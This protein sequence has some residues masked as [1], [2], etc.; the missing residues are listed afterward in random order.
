MSDYK[1]Y[2]PYDALNSPLIY[3]YREFPLFAFFMTVFFRY[4]PINLREIMDT[5]PMLN[6]KALGLIISSYSN[7]VR[8]N[9]PIVSIAEIEKLVIILLRLKSK[10]YSGVSWGYPFPW[11]NRVR[12]TERYEPSIV[13][14]S[15]VAHSLLDYYDLCNNEKI[16]MAVRKACDFITNNLNIKEFEN[17][18]CFGY[19]PGEKNVILNASAL[20]ASLLYRVGNYTDDE[21]L[22]SI[23]DKAMSFLLSRQLPD[24][25]WEYSYDFTS[26]I[27]RTQTDWHQG[28][29]LDSLIEYISNNKN[30]DLLNKL[31]LG[32]NYYKQQ[33]RKDGSSY[34]RTN[35]WGYPIN[36]HNQAQGVITFSKLSKYFPA[37]LK[38]AERI[39]GWTI[40]NLYSG[41]G[42]FYYQK[43]RFFTNT[44]SYVRWSQAW[45][46]LALTSYLLAYRRKNEAISKK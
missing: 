41:Q 13:V 33:F 37:Y 28:F 5:K 30:P 42:F 45:M 1:G 9:E 21:R 25:R 4:S 29:I 18:I 46:L 17:G 20:G 38:I 35:Q 31:E 19:H 8:L 12:L 3:K 6:P 16:I 14:T 27:P 36:I 23:A 39:L 24:G 15:F 10:E 34:W 11:R 40:S 7:I 44:I 2:D 22:E 32:A 43:G 26:D